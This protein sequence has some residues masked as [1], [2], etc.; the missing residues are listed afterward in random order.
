LECEPSEK[1]QP[2]PAAKKPSATIETLKPAHA[3]WSKQHGP[4]EEAKTKVIERRHVTHGE[5]HENEVHTP[6]HPGEREPRFRQK[7]DPAGSAHPSFGRPAALVGTGRAAGFGKP[8]YQRAHKTI[9][10]LES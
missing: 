5:L 10:R 3:E 4:H 7:L 1:E 2:D 6:D 8:G 9:G